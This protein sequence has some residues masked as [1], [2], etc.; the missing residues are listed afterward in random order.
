MSKLSSASVTSGWIL[1][2]SGEGADL[3]HK[4]CRCRRYS[5]SLLCL[6]FHLYRPC[7]GGE[8]RDGGVWLEGEEGR[9]E[10]VGRSPN[11]DIMY[12]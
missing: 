9:A 8:V 5:V 10:A 7:V 3:S 6:A 12:L 11:A 4:E 2:S 1:T